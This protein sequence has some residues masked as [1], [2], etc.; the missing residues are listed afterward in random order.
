MTPSTAARCNALRRWSVGLRVRLALVAICLPLLGPYPALAQQAAVQPAPVQSPAQARRIQHF[1]TA[2]ALLDAGEFALARDRLA[3]LRASVNSR[4]ELE[5]IDRAYGI[6]LKEAPLRFSLGFDILPSDNITTVSSSRVFNTSVGQF[7]IKGGGEEESGVGFRITGGASYTLLTRD[8]QTWSPS[9][10]LTRAQYPVKRLSFTEGTLALSWQQQR[11]RDS[12]GV[13]PYIA[14]V[15]YDSTPDRSSSH[16]K[17]GVTLSHALRLP[18]GALLSRF[19]RFEF[20]EYDEATTLNGPRFLF[21]GTYRRP[22]APRMDYSLSSSVTR[23]RPDA[24][25]LR[26]IGAS[27]TASVR[28]AFEG[29]GIVCLNASFG[30]RDYDADFPGTPTQR[31]DTDIRIGAEFTPQRLRVFRS[32]PK[33]D[34][35]LQR[36]SSNI[37]L[38]D[39]QAFQCAVSFSRAF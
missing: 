36:T 1:T 38:Y 10:R 26:Y 27:G 16:T 31:F 12:I 6:A 37:D 19:A 9:I 13:A 24:G 14:R 5:I 11:V 29:I 22:F 18:R 28:R 7:R 32:R 17:A 20:R 4:R 15:A 3:A 2:T 23:V 30:A 34:C 25:H 35:G 39:Y 33:I 8:G 21:G